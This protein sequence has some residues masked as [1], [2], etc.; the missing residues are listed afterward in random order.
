MDLKLSGERN[1]QKH[2]FPLWILNYP[3]NKKH[4]E[5]INQKE[6]LIPLLRILNYPG[7]KIHGENIPQYGY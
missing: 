2:I 6:E 5:N 1:E 4:D 3:G 7:N